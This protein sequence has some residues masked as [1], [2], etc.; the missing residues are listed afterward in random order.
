MQIAC[1]LPRKEMVDQAWRAMMQNGIDWRTYHMTIEYG[2]T[3]YAVE[4]AKRMEVS[5]EKPDIVIARG[6]QATYIKKFCSIP[7]AEIRLTAQ[8]MSL[9][10]IKAKGLTE[11][12]APRIGVVGYAN[13]FC[14]MDYFSEIFHIDLHTYLVKSDHSDRAELHACARQA[15]F[16]SMDVIIGGDLAQAEAG[17]AGIPS[18]YIES[19]G[20]SF[21]EAFRAAKS[22]AYAI[23]QEQLNTARIMTLLDNSFSSVICLDTEGRV[24]LINHVAEIELGLKPAGVTGR[25]VSDFI[26]DL[27]MDMLS[28]VLEKGQVIFSLYVDIGPR[29]IVANV[30]P[31]HTDRGIAG[32]IISAQPVK[33]LEEMGSVARQHQLSNRVAEATLQSI[34]EPS[35]AMRQM[36]SL[37][38][39]YAGS[40]FPVLIY[41]PPGNGQERFAQAIHNQSKRNNGVYI[42]ANC[43][44]ISEAEQMQALFAPANETGGLARMANGGTLYLENIHALTPACQQRLLTLLKRR[45]LVDTHLRREQIN[46]RIIASCTE[47]LYPLVKEG[48]F[49]QELYFILNTLPLE[50]PPLRERQEDIFYW[51]DQFLIRYRERYKRYITLTSGGKKQLTNY[52]WPGNV[53]QL[54]SFCQHL[55]LVARHRTIDEVDIRKLYERIYLTALPAGREKKLESADRPGSEAEL[56]AQLLTQYQGNRSRVAAAMSISVTTLW[57]K[58]KRYGLVEKEQ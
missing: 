19:T 54:R 48:K 46:V 56:I 27:N 44:E 6:L 1:L 25:K 16:D 22:I 14:N 37:A 53:L 17:Q 55:I 32:A 21:L 57:R 29:S 9:L 15:V 42:A 10:I 7:V 8:E 12:E 49:N 38:K 52:A 20:D 28:D 13:Q 45:E 58:I 43:A 5:A 51:A 24:T 11:K 23:E 40:E 47:P 39:Q 41:S 4:W 34:S 18:I 36:V 33:L 50:I 30:S 35:V 3:E 31:I 26:S 2:N